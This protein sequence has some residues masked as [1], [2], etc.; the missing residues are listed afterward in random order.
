MAKTPKKSAALT[1]Q[2][3]PIPKSAKTAAMPAG[4]KR[5]PAKSAPP[6][7]IEAI[8]ESETPGMAMVTGRHSKQAMLITLMSRAEGATL[9]D[10]TS[11]TGWQRHSVRGAISGAVKKRLGFVIASSVEE[12]GRVYRIAGERR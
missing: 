12:R 10:L 2:A 11:A 1:I 8:T 3:H 9:D 4:K 6:S 7:I 5:P